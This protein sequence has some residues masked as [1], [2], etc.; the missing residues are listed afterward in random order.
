MRTFERLI[1]AP[2]MRMFPV[3]IR[4]FDWLWTNIYDRIGGGRFEEDAEIDRLWPSGLQRP[5]RLT[6]TPWRMRLDLSQWSERRTFFSGRYYQGELTAVFRQ[7]LR[8]GDTHLDVGANIGCTVLI[9]ASVVGERGKVI[10][11]EPN[12]AVYERLKNTIVENRLSFVHALNCALGQ[13]DVQM[14]LH[15]PFGTSGAASLTGSIRGECRA[16]QVEVR[17]GEEC[18]SDMIGDSE[19]I[20]AKIDVEGFEHDVLKGLGEVLPKRIGALCVEITDS[21]LR[22]RASSAEALYSF[23]TDRGF[24]PYHLRYVRNRFSSEY[25]LDPATA[26][27]DETQYDAVFLNKA[28]PV[29][30][31][32]L[33]Q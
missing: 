10:A 25:Y 33:T 30:E 27:K 16:V 11:F 4:M 8:D 12:P 2:I 20:F 9:A 17:N 19:N 1:L 22:R 32:R 29:F 3:R 13:D 26:P 15:I 18:V 5:T 7:L 28:K 14:Q 31:S 23:L 24:R 21:L 6:P